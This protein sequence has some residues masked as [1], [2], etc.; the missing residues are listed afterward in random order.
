MEFS[1]ELQGVIG[2]FPLRA[3]QRPPLTPKWL[4]NQD[5]FGFSELKIGQAVQ[6]KDRS[7]SSR[8][9]RKIHA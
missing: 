4:K 7:V 5:L 9:P 1:S 3:H 2:F 6:L 8:Q